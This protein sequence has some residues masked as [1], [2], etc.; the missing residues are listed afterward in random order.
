MASLDNPEPVNL[1]RAIFLCNIFTFFFAASKACLFPF[2]TIFLKKLGLSATYTG[3]IIGCKTI[4]GFVFAPLWAK[5]AVRCGRRRCMLMF[6]L[7]MMALT[8]LS[9][10]AIPSMNNAFTIKCIGGYRHVNISDELAASNMK[11]K[12]TGKVNAAENTTKMIST[13]LMPSN[14]N[15]GSQV[16]V[17]G[18]PGSN[19]TKSI[20]SKK[21]FKTTIKAP[22]STV[23]RTTTAPGN[24]QLSTVL[25]Q[26]LLKTGIPPDDLE[27]LTSSELLSYVD[28]I[29]QTRDGVKLIETA[30]EELP[31]ETA[32]QLL[33]LV[34]PGG[35]RK[36]RGV[37]KNLQ[38]LQ[39]EIIH[40]LRK[41]SQEEANDQKDDDTDDDNDDVNDNHETESSWS[42]LKRK[43]YEKFKSILGDVTETEKK[44][45]VVILVILMVGE[46]FCSP[47]EKVAD[48]SWY[49]FLEGIDDLEKYGMHRVWS[50]FAFILLPIIVTLSVDNTVCLFGLS[51]HSFMLHF[52]LF[53][54]F[55]GITFLVA[56]FYPMSTSEKYKYASKVGKGLKMICCSSRG[57]LFSITLL[58]MGIVYSSYYN[59]LF[60]MLIDMGSKEIT[61][62][63]CLTIAALAEI[64]MLLFND[65]LVRKIGNGGVVALSVFLLS[66]RVLYYSFLPTP[67]AVLPAELLH[68]FTHTA[69][70]WAILSSP[71]F[72][73]SPALSRSIRSIFSSI[74]FGIGFAV[75]SIASGLIYD[76]FGSAILFQAGAVM[77]IAWFP[78]LLCGVR[79]CRESEK[80]EVKYSKLLTSDNDSSD[81]EDDWLEHALKNK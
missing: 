44:M 66:G 61:L 31:E 3:A 68:A 70:W 33:D 60:W 10:T 51:L 13:T 64:P 15:A 12:P 14:E 4:V 54:V 20:S 19:F 11:S 53:G 48:D 73:V 6:S 59:F 16:I 69:T 40:E 74:Y 72:N 57:L 26:L 7:F 65:K 71:S 28:S 39:S 9:L 17:T 29:I 43:F 34:G 27:G 2:L 23:F 22:K 42:A 35:R 38:R 81:L 67:W 1:A 77:A 49:E 52:Y 55:I 75:G 21:P 47:I 41:R 56:F 30:L 24:E 36:K 25:K 79:C 76:N 46:M 62:G 80:T 18:L 50:S 8:Y 58:V 5:C 45:F 32:D 37:S 63:L 78:V